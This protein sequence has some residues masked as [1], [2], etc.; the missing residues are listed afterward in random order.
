MSINRALIGSCHEDNSGFESALR[1]VEKT[2]VK[3]LDKALSAKSRFNTNGPTYKRLLEIER[4]PLQ[5]CLRKLVNHSPWQRGGH[6]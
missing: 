6:I 2:V 3:L 5:N 4:S 1:L